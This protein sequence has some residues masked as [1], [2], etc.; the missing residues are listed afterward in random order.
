MPQLD[1]MIQ[2][3]TIIIFVEADLTTGSEWSGYETT[4][5]EGTQK[6]IEVIE[7]NEK[8]LALKPFVL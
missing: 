4:G 8:F 3:Y 6:I 7:Y 1:R 2:Q 5:Q